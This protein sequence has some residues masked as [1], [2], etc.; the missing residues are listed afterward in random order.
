MRK[1]VITLLVL[2][3]LIAG[4][5]LLVHKEEKIA[6]KNVAEKQNETVIVAN[7]KEIPGTKYC[8][9]GIFGFSSNDTAKSVDVSP[10]DAKIKVYYPDPRFTQKDPLPEGVMRG[11][12]L[13]KGMLSLMPDKEG[14]SLTLIE[15]NVT[16][17]WA[18]FFVQREHI[19]LN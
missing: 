7:G 9:S 16:E 17:N 12:T 2:I 15:G 18:K 1:L 11:Y 19:Y 4:V 6:D 5:S 8:L 14:I 10:C 13:K 3:V